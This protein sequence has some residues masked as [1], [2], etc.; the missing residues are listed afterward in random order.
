MFRQLI[1]ILKQ[2]LGILIA[3]ESGR[4]DLT[5]GFNLGFAQLYKNIRDPDYEVVPDWGPFGKSPIGHSASKKKQPTKK[6]VNLS[7]IAPM[8]Y[9][10]VTSQTVNP[11]SGNVDLSGYGH[12]VDTSAEETADLLASLAHQE[13]IIRGQL[14]RLGNTR[15]VGLG[16]I[17]SSYNQAVNRLKGQKAE[18]QR[19]YTT[20]TEDVTKGFLGSRNQI[21]SDTRAR[22]NNLRRIL[23]MAGSG[24]SSASETAA[25]YAALREGSQR[26][27]PV[28]QTYATN[29]RDLDVNW[30]D[31]LR[32]YREKVGDVGNQRYSLIQGLNKSI[33]ETRADLL[34][35]LRTIGVSREQARGRSL[36]EAIASQRGLEGEVGSLRDR[37]SKLGRQYAKPVVKAGN[38]VYEDPEIGEYIIGPEGE[39]ITDFPGAS[40]ID[41]YFAPV[42]RDEEEDALMQPA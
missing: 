32:D 26:L 12:Q 6:N 19:D 1:K 3:D 24:N 17:G 39:I 21:A 16:N 4:V 34:D 22:L 36:E 30:E 2:K 14:G 28:Q 18:A 13:S 35:K 40:D 23:G 8:A 5:P 37:I 31:T 42:L 25:P 10:P 15:K 33:G 38:I 11:G 20:G 9:K 27:A 29:R 7:P 41:P